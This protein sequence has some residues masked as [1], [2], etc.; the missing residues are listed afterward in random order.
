MHISKI[1][2][3]SLV[4]TAFVLA[5]G[6]AHAANLSFSG[7]SATF[8]QTFAGTWTAAQSID[9]LIPAPGTPSSGWAIFDNG[10]TASQTALFELSTPLAPGAYTL[11]YTLTQNYGSNHTLDTFSL[12]Y[13]TAAGPGLAS[14][15]TLVSISS[16]SSSGGATLTPTGGNI[17]ASGTPLAT[18]VY[19]IVANINAGA[20]VTG[21]FL[22]AIDNPGA[23]PG[24]QGNGNFVLTEF[25]VNAAPVPE[26]AQW[27]L[28]AAGLAAISFVAKRRNS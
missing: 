16:A 3:A 1:G 23:G 2:T 28:M 7:A 15:Q 12:A 4:A 11:T 24:R 27:A 5:Q 21:L 26:P 9:G 19:T 25:A 18:D 14:P 8:E 20:P 6:A 22:N 10:V 17:D 13:T